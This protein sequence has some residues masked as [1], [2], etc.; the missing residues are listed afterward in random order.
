MNSWCLHQ[1]LSI[2][3]LENRSGVRSARELE[4]GS[5]VGGLPRHPSLCGMLA[6]WNVA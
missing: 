3:L 6:V 5:G 1:T 4:L 2:I